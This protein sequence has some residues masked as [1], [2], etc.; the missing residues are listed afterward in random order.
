MLERHP[1]GGDRQH[2]ACPCSRSPRS[3]EFADR[4]RSSL[5]L[6]APGRREVEQRRGSRGAPTAMRGRS[7]PKI[8]AGPG[9]HPLEQRLEREQARLDEMRCR[10]RRTRSRARSRRTAPPRTARPSP[11]ASAARGRSRSPRSS[12]R[13]ARRC[14]AA[15]SSSVRSGGFIF[16]FGSSVRTA[17]SVRQRWC[18]VDLGRSR[19]TP[20]RAARGEMLDRLARGEVHQV[21]RLPGVAREVDV[22]R[23]HQ[24][25]AERRPAAEPELGRD[26]ARVR[27]AAARERRLLAVDGDRAAGDRVVLQ[28]AP[29]HARPP[30]PDGRRR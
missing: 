12:R 9:G 8:A 29:H 26:R 16:R 27:V 24:A 17:S 20:R 25:L 5:G 4:E 23:D 6:D 28:R 14:S 21:H 3:H 22:A 18:G 1:A 11:R 10:A 30:R 19:A 15:R 13:A 7:S 2:D